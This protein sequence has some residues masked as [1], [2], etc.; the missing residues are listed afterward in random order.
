MTT[1]GAASKVALAIFAGLLA[2]T[3]VRTV[4][5]VAGAASVIAGAA[6]WWLNGRRARPLYMRAA[7]V[8]DAPDDPGA[9]AGGQA[10]D[11]EEP[12]LLS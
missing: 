4:G 7:S 11:M 2:V 3:G 5:I 10:A 9:V 6:W 8:A 12:V 1:Y